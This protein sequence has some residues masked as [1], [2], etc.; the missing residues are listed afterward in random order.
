MFLWDVHVLWIGKQAAVVLQHKQPPLIKGTNQYSEFLCL[1][2]CIHFGPKLCSTMNIYVSLL[3]LL[4]FSFN[5]SA[6]ASSRVVCLIC[7]IMS[8]DSEIQASLPRRDAS[9]VHRVCLLEP[10]RFRLAS[11]L[12]ILKPRSFRV[13]VL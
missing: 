7:L 1:Q 5:F 4:Y 10:L 8:L 13:R 2:I 9:S 11:I 3:R 6:V 12:Q